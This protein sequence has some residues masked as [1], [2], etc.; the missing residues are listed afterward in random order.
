MQIWIERSWHKPWLFFCSDIPILS[1]IPNLIHVFSAHLMNCY[2][3]D[4]WYSH[5]TEKRTLRR[6][7][8]NMRKKQDI[9]W[10]QSTLWESVEKWVTKYLK[11][12]HS[13]QPRW[14][15]RWPLIHNADLELKHPDVEK[16]KYEFKKFADKHDQLILSMKKNGL[17]MRKCFGF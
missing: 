7:K 8:C 11:K 4:F 12:N 3:P 17:S 6:E 5:A 14:Q 1:T 10:E 2:F 9:M 15:E 13:E 16:C